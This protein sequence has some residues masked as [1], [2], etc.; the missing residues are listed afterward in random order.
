M[1]GNRCAMQ[2]EI[3]LD[4]FG[5]PPV[6]FFVGGE[7]TSYLPQQE[8]ILSVQPEL[9]AWMPVPTNRHVRYTHFPTSS[10][11]KRVGIPPKLT[12]AG[13]PGWWRGP[14]ARKWVSDLDSG[15]KPQCRPWLPTWFTIHL[16]L[17]CQTYVWLCGP[18]RV[19]GGQHCAVLGPCLLYH[20]LISSQS[21]C[22]HKP[23]VDTLIS[24]LGSTTVRL[25]TS[26]VSA[27]H[28]WYLVMAALTYDHAWRPGRALLF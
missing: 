13:L 14:V 4:A 5:S 26:F 18:Y 25:Y 10:L 9:Q 22:N 8:E 1:G 23:S 3:H 16:A 27:T 7:K 2:S 15:W 24:G 11:G 28:L 6:P 21:Q 12:H 19:H 20:F 17:E